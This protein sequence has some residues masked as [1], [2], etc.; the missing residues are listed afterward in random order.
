MCRNDV[1][2]VFDDLMQ[3][4]HIHTTPQTLSNGS[5]EQMET[6]VLLLG[7]LFFF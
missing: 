4:L 6:S 7:P 1:Q 2:G 3:S 5:L